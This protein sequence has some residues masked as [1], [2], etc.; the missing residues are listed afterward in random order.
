MRRHLSSVMGSVENQVEENVGDRRFV[1]LTGEPLKGNHLREIPREQIGID[2][3]MFFRE[4]FEFG[5]R[6]L[7]P[8][9]ATRFLAVN[10]LEPGTLAKHDVTDSLA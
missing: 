9:L 4:L 1:L 2:P 8:D 6:Q 3:M 7:T 5:E 10:S